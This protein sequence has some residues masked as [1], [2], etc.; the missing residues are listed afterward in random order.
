M[1]PTVHRQPL[2]KEVVAKL[3]DKGKLVDTASLQP[4]KVQ[5]TAWFCISLFPEK[6]GHKNQQLA[7]ARLEKNTNW[8][9]IFGNEQRTWISVDDQKPSGWPRRQRRRGKRQNY[10]RHLAHNAAR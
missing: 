7:H 1:A 3:Y 8:L 2:T 4:H 5:Q 9:K 6:R 10:S